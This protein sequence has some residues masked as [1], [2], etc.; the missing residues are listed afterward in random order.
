MQYEVTIMVLQVFCSDNNEA[1]GFVLEAV[2]KEANQV[3]ISYYAQTDLRG[4]V[5]IW[6][7][8]QTLTNISK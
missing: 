3:K 8:N 5:P 1:S 7:M 6:V 4:F 2:E